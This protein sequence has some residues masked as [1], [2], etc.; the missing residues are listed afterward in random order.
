MVKQDEE[1]PKGTE[2]DAAHPN[3]EKRDEKKAKG[4]E[5]DVAHT[6]KEKQDEE[7]PKGTENN[8]AHPNKEKQDEENPRGTENDATDTSMVKQD[9][10]KPKGAKNDGKKDVE[11][12][13][14]AKNDATHSTEGK[15][16]GKNSD[17]GRNVESMTVI[18][19]A[20]LTPTFNINFQQGDKVV[21]RGGSPFSWHN[22]GQQVE[23][24]PVRYGSNACCFLFLFLL[25]SIFFLFFISAVN[26]SIKKMPNHW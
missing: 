5:N 7:K 2:N 24:H 4:T 11:K 22:P 21:L 20:L 19:H 17:S 23:M 16:D 9:E 3:K 18:F 15:K 10:G 13:Q 6:N 12:N 25:C 8:T 14:G 26:D 1:K